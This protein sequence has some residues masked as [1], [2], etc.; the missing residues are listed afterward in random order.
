MTNNIACTCSHALAH[1]YMLVEL[2]EDEDYGSD[3]EGDG[4]AEANP[5]ELDTQV[6]ELIESVTAR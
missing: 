1:R 4:V 2:S 6:K 5:S 3:E